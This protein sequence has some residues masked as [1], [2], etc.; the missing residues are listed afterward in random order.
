MVQWEELAALAAAARQ[1]YGEGRWPR[2]AVPIGGPRGPMSDDEVRVLQQQ[3][4]GAELPDDLRQLLLRVGP[5]CFGEYLGQVGEASSARFLWSAG[6]D[7]DAIDSEAG[8]ADV[9]SYGAA[10]AAGPDA[11]PS[12]AEWLAGNYNVR[13][14]Q[15]A[16]P[17]YPAG[18]EPYNDPIAAVVM[19]GPLRGRLWVF[20]RMN[21]RHGP[22]DSAGGVGAA[23]LGQWLDQYWVGALSCALVRA[24]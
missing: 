4:G 14:M 6:A 1:A 8:W 7:C 17:L 11:A 12:T 24:A 16:V 13:E 18:R 23:T 15:G 9:L 22:G 3:L 2:D 21:F 19:T 20:D 10:E 5:L